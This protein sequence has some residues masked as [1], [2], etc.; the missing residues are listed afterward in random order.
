MNKTWLGIFFSA[1][2]WSGTYPKDYLIWILET[3]PAIIAFIV[4]ITTRQT[5]RLTDLAY[6][7]ILVHSLILMVGGHYTYADVPL[8]DWLKDEFHFERNN[9][10]KVGHFAQGF[11]PAIIAREILIRKQVVVNSRWLH[12]FVVCICLAISAFYEL[13]EWWV[14]LLSREAA[15]A[16]LG[17]QGYIWDTQSDMAYALLGV[18]L[19]LAM[20]SRLHDRQ[21]GKLAAGSVN[22]S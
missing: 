8:F 14:A 3:A 22:A 2:I 19:A 21:L 13:I 9:Y 5:F 4:L 12:F 7:L 17:T 6:S 16:F 20:L 18:M 15:E 1:L 11:I 10:D